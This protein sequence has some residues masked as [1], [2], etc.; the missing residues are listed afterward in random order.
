MWRWRELVTNNFSPSLE[1]FATP[2][3]SRT[4]LCPTYSVPHFP[5][6]AKQFACSSPLKNKSAKMALMFLLV[7]MGGNELQIFFCWKIS[8]PR[9]GRLRSLRLFDFPSYVPTT[10]KKPPFREFLLCCGDGGNRIPVQKVIV[11]KSTCLFRFLF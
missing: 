3:R 6:Q 4:I 9:L 2:T 10:K 11:K 5:T 1:I 8:Q 7:E